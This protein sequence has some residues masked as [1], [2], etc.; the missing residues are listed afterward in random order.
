MFESNLNSLDFFERFRADEPDA[1]VAL[2]KY[3]REHFIK[4]YRYMGFTDDE[5]N[6]LW[7]ETYVNLLETK[8]ATY[9]STKAPFRIWLKVVAKRAGLYR[10]RERA[11]HP[12]ISLDACLDIPSNEIFVEEN[13]SGKSKSQIRVR[14]ATAS[15]RQNDQTILWERFVEK[16]TFD[17]IAEQFGISESAARMRVSRGLERLRQKLERLCSRELPRRT[18]RTRRGNPPRAAPARNY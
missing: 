16:L 2:W 4:L 1:Q 6:D 12:E 11:Q 14:R 13:R 18:K 5:A 17:L 10:L 3:G 15:L 8:C 9:N 7:S